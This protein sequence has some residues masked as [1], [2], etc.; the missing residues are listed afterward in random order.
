MASGVCLRTAH[1]LRRTA[2]DLEDVARTCQSVADRLTRVQVDGW[3][4]LAAE[5]FD[6]NRLRQLKRWRAAGAA[7]SSTSTALYA[8]ASDLDGCPL[9]QVGVQDLQ[10]ASARVHTRV[11]LVARAITSAAAGAPR[12]SAFGGTASALGSVGTID[13]GG[14]LEQF[15]ATVVNASASLVQAVQDN[16]QDV[17]AVIAGAVLIKL[18]SSGELIGI[19]LDATGV[20]AVA[21]VP[22]GVASTA[23]IAVG[24]GLV[25]GGGIHLVQAALAN[26]VE[27]VSAGT[28]RPSTP[29][30]RLKEHLTRRDLEAARRELDGEV[31]ATKSGGKPYDH[32][33]EVREAQAGL[34]NRIER[35]KRLLGDSRTLPGER[36]ALEEELSEASRLLDF[37][38][39]YVP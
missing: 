7:I 38:R 15:H 29:T 30:D 26:P 23:A 1:D 17:A 13:T 37:T 32:V 28:G 8:A 27:I 12:E 34:S 16:P 25:A 14:A 6:R 31:V 33:T 18:G 9:C 35:L 11:D 10:G 2:V 39:G 3:L 21:G 20:G 24:T 22:M 36:P 19:A 4:G 5:A